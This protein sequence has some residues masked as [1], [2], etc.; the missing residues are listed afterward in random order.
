M[1]KDEAYLVGYTTGDGSL[2]SFEHQFSLEPWK[3]L[4]GYELCWGDKDKQQLE[5]IK[6]I[7]EEKLPNIKARIKTRKNSKGLV[8]KCTRKIA[9]Q[10][11][12]KLLGQDIT[13]EPKEVIASYISGFCDAEADVSRTTNTIVKNKRYYRK[14]IQITQKDK[15][16]LE[17]IGNL[18]KDN[19]GIGSNMYKKWKQDAYVLVV[20]C[21]QRVKLF[22]EYIHFR[23]P[24]KRSKLNGLFPNVQSSH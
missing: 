23:N 1:D 21:D 15:K 14:R 17:K 3:T 10:Y 2:Y 13:K 24:T 11:V 8:L 9:Y 4:K 16:L 7:I 22:K 18:M 20:A 5:I 6:G 12:E 19:F